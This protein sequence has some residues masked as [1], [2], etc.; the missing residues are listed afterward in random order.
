MRLALN[1]QSCVVRKSE[2]RSEMNIEDGMS[3]QVQGRIRVPV[4]GNRCVLMGGSD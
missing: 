4:Q 2:P 1:V 3:V